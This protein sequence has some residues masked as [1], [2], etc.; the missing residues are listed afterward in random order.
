L[1]A[2][3][4]AGGDWNRDLA[5]DPQGSIYFA[6]HAQGD[7]GGPKQGD[8]IDS[9]GIV[10]KLSQTVPEPGSFQLLLLSLYAVSVMRVRNRNEQRSNPRR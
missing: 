7:F 6:G 2:A 10:A 5:I 8:H 4:S 1:D 9:D 3:A